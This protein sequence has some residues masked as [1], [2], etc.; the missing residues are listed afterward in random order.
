MHA[1]REERAPVEDFV[2]LLAVGVVEARVQ[3]RRAVVVLERRPGSVVVGELSAARVALRA[4]VELTLRGPRLAPGGVASCGVDHPGDTAAFVEGH[5]EAACVHG[6]PRRCGVLRKGNVA[7]TRPVAGLA[8]D[9]H[10]RVRGRIGVRGC[11]VVLLDVRGVAVGAHEVPVLLPPRPVQLV[12]VVDA[13]AGIEVE[14]ALPA[15]LLR[16]CVP[17]DRKGLNVAARQLDEV[18]LQR[19][20]AE[21]VADLEVRELA[22]RAVGADHVLAV[23]PEEAAGD[24]GVVEPRLVEVTE[25]G[26]FVGHLHGDRVLRTPPGL[27][28]GSVAGRAGGRS[29][30]SR[31]DGRGGHGRR[32]WIR[33]DGRRRGRL[34]TGVQP[35]REGDTQGDQRAQGHLAGSRHGRHCDARMPRKTVEGRR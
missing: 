11:V 12:A 25:D 9:A 7:A 35:Q 21:R 22:V 34:S 29:H 4:D 2:A 26:A 27:V 8:A 33:S 14:P 31:V 1:A 5:R 3:Q 23:P 16:A 20:H 28:L 17:G 32:G 6:A 10:F 15:L 24:A 19:I 30:V 13:L 18:L